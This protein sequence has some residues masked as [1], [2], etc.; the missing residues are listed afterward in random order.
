MHAG[1][2]ARGIHSSM[3]PTPYLLPASQVPEA[4]RATATAGSAAAAGATA[5]TAAATAK[6]YYVHVCHGCGVPTYHPPP[7][8]A[9][10]KDG[11]GRNSGHNNRHGMHGGGL[12]H[13]HGVVQ[14]LHGLHNAHAAAVAIA[15]HQQ[16]H[17]A[18]H[19]NFNNVYQMLAAAPW[20]G[21]PLV[22]AHAVHPFG[23]VAGGGVLGAGGGHVEPMI[24][25]SSF[26]LVAFQSVAF[27][28]VACNE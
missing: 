27:Q 28:Q 15:A 9:D 7:S 2:G 18:H 16:N 20:H 21:H 3:H 13:P 17:A 8:A 1:F 19:Q 14:G 26:Q 5:N 25:V 24:P 11:S 22:H 4:H 6:P 12:L 10:G 23:V